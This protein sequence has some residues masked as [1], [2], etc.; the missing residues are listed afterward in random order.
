[1]R[2][3]CFGMV[4]LGMIHPCSRRHSLNLIF[5]YY[6]MIAN[7]V[8]VLQRAFKNYGY[9]LH[10]FMEVHSKTF[11]CINNIVVKNPQCSKPHSFWIVVISKAEAVPTKKPVIF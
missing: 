7:A 3:V 2:L 8:S 6:S 1:M 10:A 5:F 4:E 9:N 11:S